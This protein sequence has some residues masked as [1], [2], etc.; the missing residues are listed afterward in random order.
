MNYNSVQKSLNPPYSDNVLPRKE[1]SEVFPS[2]RRYCIRVGGTIVF[3]E[4]SCLRRKELYINSAC[5]SEIY[6]L[7]IILRNR[8]EYEVPMG[9]EATKGEEGGP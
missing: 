8:E 5:V 2:R 4:I 9:R 3:G 6:L 1:Q 7:D